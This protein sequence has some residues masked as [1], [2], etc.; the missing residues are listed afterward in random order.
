MTPDRLQLV[1]ATLRAEPWPDDP[2]A[3]ATELEGLADANPRDALVREAVLQ[4]A[5]QDAA[6]HL[7]PDVVGG[8][9]RERLVRW[10]AWTSTWDGWRVATGRA[11]RVRVV[12]RWANDPAHARALIRDGRAIRGLVPVTYSGEP[13]PALTADLD[14]APVTSREVMW[15]AEHLGASV[16]SALASLARWEAARVLPASIEASSLVQGPTG[17]H[18]SCLTPT[19]AFGCRRRITELSE[20]LLALAG[21]GDDPVRSVL[22]GMALMA[23]AT[24]EEAGAFATRALAEDLAARRHRVVRRHERV[25]LEQR[26]AALGAA[27][28]RLQRA[29]PPP[30]GRGALGVDLDGNV[31]VVT[32]DDAGVAW[33]PVGG[34]AHVVLPV[35]GPLDTREARRMLRSGAAAPPSAHLDVKVGGDPAF[36]SSIARWTSAAI[37]LRTLRRLLEVTGPG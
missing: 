15:S 6:G 11:A 17:L 8:V 33:G 27:L 14:G 32:S 36:S 25:V 19:D 4:L 26:R 10:D 5:R 31:L 37:G 7:V 29:C 9:R 16:A 22:E 28:V 2:V 23:P 12:E 30:I 34:D 35:G 21:P 3:R 18:L 24:T 13:W 20:V 1:L